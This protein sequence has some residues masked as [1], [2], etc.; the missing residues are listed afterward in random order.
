MLSVPT[1]LIPGLLSQVNLH[2]V[3]VYARCNCI[4]SRVQYEFYCLMN[5]HDASVRNNDMQD[6]CHIAR[7]N[8]A[9][10]AFYTGVRFVV[11][12]VQSC[13]PAGLFGHWIRMDPD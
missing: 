5:L 1:K 12:E 10:F 2:V 4:E 7:N 6:L 3:S 9:F 8:N 13:Q 11:A